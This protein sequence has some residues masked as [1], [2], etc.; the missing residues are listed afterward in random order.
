MHTVE[1]AND[2]TVYLDFSTADAFLNA[3]EILPSMALFQYATSST[4]FSRLNSG[5]Q[6]SPAPPKSNHKTGPFVAMPPFAASFFCNCRHL[7]YIW[8][9]RVGVEPTIRPAK[10]RIA[11]FEGREDHRTPFASVESIGSGA[12]S[13]N[14]GGSGFGAD[15]RCDQVV[16]LG[17]RADFVVGMGRGCA[18][19]SVR[20]EF[21]SQALAQ[22]EQFH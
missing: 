20:Q 19:F 3:V 10:G 7:I 8:R 12:D 18:D 6:L 4:C 15:Q 17:A 21:A 11:G 1:P 14:C 16:E 5:I 13:F 22:N 2:G 9:K